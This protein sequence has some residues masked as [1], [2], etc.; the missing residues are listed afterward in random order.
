M[1]DLYSNIKKRRL[2]LGLTQSE[3]A[4]KLGYSDKSMI[5]KIESGKVDLAQSKI[6]A[7]ADALQVTP[8]YLMGWE[9]DDDSSGSDGHYTNPETAATAQEL[10]DRPEMRILFDAAQDAKPEDL[11]KAAEYLEFLKWGEKQIEYEAHR[12][13]E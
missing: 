4:E 12:G 10:F 11:R 8:A 5:A 9:S 7:F 3:L 6:V 1:L 13:A 2:E